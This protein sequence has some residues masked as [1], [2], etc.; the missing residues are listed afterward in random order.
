MGSIGGG[1]EGCTGTDWCVVLDWAQRRDGS[2]TAMVVRGSQ[3]RRGTRARGRL[4]W[5]DA[6]DGNGAGTAEARQVASA[7]SNGV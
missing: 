2:P 7:A 6:G 4:E 3:T 5:V 1:I